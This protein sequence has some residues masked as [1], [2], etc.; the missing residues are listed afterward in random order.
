[1]KRR[2]FLA[3]LGLVPLAAT[4]KTGS[5]SNPDRGTYGDNDIATTG[6]IRISNKVAP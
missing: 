3:A 4:E 6:S 5:S 2:S 1:M